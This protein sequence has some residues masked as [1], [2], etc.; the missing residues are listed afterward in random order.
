MVD[1][2][3]I[4]LGYLIDKAD[5]VFTSLVD[6]AD[7]VC[8]CVVDKTEIVFTLLIDKTG[9][10]TRL[11]D[12]KDIFLSVWSIKQ[13]L[14]P[15]QWIK[16]IRFFF[17]DKA[18]IVF[19]PLADKTER[20]TCLADKT[21]RYICLAD[22]TEHYTCLADKTE[23]FTGLVDKTECFTCLVDKT[24]L[25]TFFL[26]FQLFSS[27]KKSLNQKIWKNFFFFFI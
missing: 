11:V 6:K 17:V 25:N 10:Y 3:D 19:D 1:K 2:A 22:K 15:A 4:L 26:K 20:Y 18:D 5:S 27:Q 12:R 23:L 13:F 16:Q 9:R 21:E 14:L 24:E 7:S 8:V